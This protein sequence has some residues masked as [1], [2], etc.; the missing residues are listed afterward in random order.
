[1]TLSTALA[2]D[3]YLCI[4]EQSTGFSPSSNKWQP[5][6]FN[7]DNERFV[8]RRKRESDTIETTWLVVALGK[9]WPTAVCDDDFTEY[10]WLYCSGL[11]YEWRINRKSLRFMYWYYMGY[12][13]GEEDTGDTPNIT[14]G[15]CAAL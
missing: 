9:N 12:V 13:R 8:L 14:I 11:G 1:L 4:S 6:S 15:K 7:V 3:Q 10:G 5:A 2:Q